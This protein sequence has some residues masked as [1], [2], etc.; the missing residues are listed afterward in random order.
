MARKPKAPPTIEWP[1]DKVERRPLTALIPNPRNAREHTPQQ[2]NQ[3]IASMREWG[4]T[5]PILVD[6]GGNII[7]G[8]GRVLAATKM[9][10]KE[11]PV[12]VA[13][14]WTEQQKRAYGI[15]DNRL[16]DGSGWNAPN[17]RLELSDLKLGGYNI[18]LLAFSAPEL[19]RLEGGFSPN[20][21]PNAGGMNVTAGDITDA[22]TKL[23]SAFTDASQ[24][25]IIF[26]EC[27]HCG[28]K[29]GINRE[30]LK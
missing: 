19:K 29:F 15:A 3:I 12:I 18:D 27:P 23:G 10:L 2:V 14:G 13:T 1:A 20:L 8:H 17:L 4:W 25:N 7:A 5:M 6:E 28:Q 9:G 21:R 24:Q 26:M 30:D 11:A 16:G 22:Q